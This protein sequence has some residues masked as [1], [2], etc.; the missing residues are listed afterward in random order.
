MAMDDDLGKNP[1]NVSET[2][3]EQHDE[4]KEEEHGCF[5]FCRK[6]TWRERGL[7]LYGGL[8]AL[9]GFASF[10]IIVPFFP[11]TVNPSATPIG[12]EEGRQQHNDWSDRRGFFSGRIPLGT[13][14]RGIRMLAKLRLTWENREIQVENN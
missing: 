10:S 9:F 7:L 8:V 4:N 5:E 12:G 1:G 3:E 13:D 2:M 14:R 11:A 6:S